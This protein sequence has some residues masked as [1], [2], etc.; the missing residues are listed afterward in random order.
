MY[1][2]KRFSTLYQK[3]YA[4]FGQDLNNINDAAKSGNLNKKDAMSSWSKSQTQANDFMNSDAFKNASAD[5]QAQYKKALENR[6]NNFKRSMQGTYEAP[7]AAPTPT[8]K[9]AIVTPPPSQQTPK[10]K[11]GMK[12]G[13]WG[14]AGLIG[15]GIAGL[16]YAAYKVGQN[17]KQSA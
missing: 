9:P 11:S 15:A 5:R 1:K 17:N 2:I 8:N 12:I 7:K 6:E 4:G 3:E 14:K 10:P 13:K 16:G